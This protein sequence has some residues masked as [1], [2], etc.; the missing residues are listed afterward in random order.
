MKTKDITLDGVL[1]DAESL[2]AEEREMLEDLLRKRRVD[3]WRR[4]TAAAAR[5]AAKAVAAGKLKGQPVES[6][7]QQLRGSR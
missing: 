2:P 3:A 7:I 5:K 4:E 6:V 1:S